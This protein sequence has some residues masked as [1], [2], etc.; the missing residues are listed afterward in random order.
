MTTEEAGSARQ[1]FVSALMAAIAPIVKDYVDVAIEK[2]VAP[3]REKLAEA[4]RYKGVWQPGVI[5]KTGSFVTY[6]GSLWHANETAMSRPGSGDAAW[7]LAVKR[8][9]K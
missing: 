7:T 5:Y 2:A 8:V 3:L 1:K 4:P 6:D 9:A